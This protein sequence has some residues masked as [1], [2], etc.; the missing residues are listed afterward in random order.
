ML[1]F[2]EVFIRYFLNLRR[3]LSSK[4]IKKVI[5]FLWHKRSTLKI[6]GYVVYLDKHDKNAHYTWTLYRGTSVQF[7][8]IGAIVLVCT[9]GQCLI[10]SYIFM[11]YGL[12]GS[13]CVCGFFVIVYHYNIVTGVF[14]TKLYY[15][16][17]KKKQNKSLVPSAHVIWRQ[18]LCEYFRSSSNG[19]RRDTSVVSSALDVA[20]T[21][22]LPLHA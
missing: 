20:Q 13:D 12:G 6:T 2:Y 16:V 21:I 11:S 4:F 3:I 18:Y 1:W 19:V 9:R 7:S 10:C 15:Y 8:Y 5:Y 14:L 22:T 17:K